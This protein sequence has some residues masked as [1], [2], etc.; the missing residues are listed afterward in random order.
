MV[1]DSGLVLWIKT[2]EKESLSFSFSL[3]LMI[4]C[5]GVCM[6]LLR[7]RESGGVM[8]RSLGQDFMM[9]FMST[10]FDIRNDAISLSSMILSITTIHS[11][12]F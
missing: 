5:W 11:I 12:T 2:R 6:C 9:I 10:V 7:E 8:L 1:F 3:G 4:G